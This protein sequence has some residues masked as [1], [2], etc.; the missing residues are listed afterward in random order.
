MKRA[1]LAL[2]VAFTLLAPVQP[3]ARAASQVSVYVE[4]Q[5]GVAPLVAF[6]QDARHTLDGEVY[7]LTSK[8]VEA[9]LVAAA[10]RGVVVRIELEPHP[11]GA[12]RRS[13]ERLQD[14]GAT[15]RA[16]GVD[17]S[18]AFTFTH[19]K[20]LVADAPARLDRLAQLD[21][22]RVQEQP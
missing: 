10:R 1:I 4:P 3:P 21:R 8:P 20:Y 15:W 2:A 7:E 18:S 13:P 6:I 19:A 14:A 9:A 5:A 16:R 22:R 17:S 11:E 12:S